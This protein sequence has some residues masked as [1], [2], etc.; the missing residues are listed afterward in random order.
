M[1]LG[2]VLSDL[3]SALRTARHQ[4]RL[5]ALRPDRTPSCDNASATSPAFPILEP[6]DHQTVTAEEWLKARGFPV[7]TPASPMPPN[8]VTTLLP[9]SAPL[10]TPE[11]MALVAEHTASAKPSPPASETTA[12]T[13][14]ETAGPT[15]E[16][17]TYEGSQ[18]VQLIERHE[19]SVPIP[20]TIAPA[21]LKRIQAAATEIAH[22]Y[23]AEQ[24]TTADVWVFDSLEDTSDTDGELVAGVWFDILVGKGNTNGLV[25]SPRWQFWHQRLTAMAARQRGA[26]RDTALNNGACSGG[27]VIDLEDYLQ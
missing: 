23:L 21:E 24:G 8:S 13:T 9:S 1:M 6:L 20:R 19:V 11:T 4:L 2:V 7:P 18:L 22:E 27:A 15:S 17:P 26:A 5:I 3:A 10:L 16:L 25:H 14:T 12:S